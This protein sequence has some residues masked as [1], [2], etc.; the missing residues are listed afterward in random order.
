M[1]PDD[2]LRGVAVS[3]ADGRPVSFT[4]IAIW[5]VRE[6]KLAA[7]GG[8]FLSGSEGIYMTTRLRSVVLALLSVLPTARQ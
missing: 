4:G 3:A 2:A 7:R 1:Q 6:G 5:K 8:E